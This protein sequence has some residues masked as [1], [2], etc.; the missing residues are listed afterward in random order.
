MLNE[1][2]DELLELFLCLRLFIHA[3]TGLSSRLTRIVERLRG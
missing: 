1:I 3:A 2:G